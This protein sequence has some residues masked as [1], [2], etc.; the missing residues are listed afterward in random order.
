MHVFFIPYGKRD[1]VEVLFRD[2]ESQAYIMPI[3]KEGKEDLGQVV[4]GG[5]RMLPFGVADYVFPKE[6]LDTVV[7][8]LKQKEQLR[9]WPAKKANPVIKMAVLRWLLGR[10][11]DYKSLPKEL[12]DSKKFQW[13]M[14]HT[15]ILVLGYKE[16]GELTEPSFSQLAGWRHE[17]I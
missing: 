17:A 12:D 14:K 1:V 15:R 3:H 8:T 2:M 7:S 9:G 11:F 6:Y 13:Y 5:I 4:K 16:D 10:V